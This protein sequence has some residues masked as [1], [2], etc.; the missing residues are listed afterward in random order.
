MYSERHQENLKRYIALIPNTK[1]GICEVVFKGY[2]ND[3]SPLKAGSKVCDT[4]YRE[5]V[6]PERLEQYLKKMEEASEKS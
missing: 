3:P 1:C 6:M 2:G 5:Y 4:C